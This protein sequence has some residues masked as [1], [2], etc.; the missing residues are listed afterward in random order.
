MMY[1]VRQRLV[2]VSTA[3]GVLGMTGFTSYL[4]LVDVGQAKEGETVLVSGAAGGV[5]SNVGWIA[6]N[7]GCRVVGI[8]GT[9][10]KCRHL[11]GTL[12]Y[13]AAIDYRADD[14]AAKLREYCPDGVDVF[15]DNVGGEILDHGLARAQSLRP[16]RVLRPHRRVPQGAGRDLPAA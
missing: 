7:L 4:G 12:G 2:P 9:A 10:E 16:G 3:I 8:A 15:F 6:R 13:D 11:T 5:G 1:K 14:V